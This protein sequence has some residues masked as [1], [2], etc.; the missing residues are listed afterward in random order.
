MQR[1]SLLFKSL[2]QCLSEACIA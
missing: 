2:T 1:Y